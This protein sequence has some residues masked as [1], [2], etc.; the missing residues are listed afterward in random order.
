[1]IL[2]HLIGMKGK[3]I[4]ITLFTCTSNYRENHQYMQ[5]TDKY[6][7]RLEAWLNKVWCKNYGRLSFVEFYDM[8]YDV[9]CL[10]LPIAGGK[11]YVEKS[12]LYS[13]GCEDNM[14]TPKNL[15]GGE[16]HIEIR[17]LG[18]CAVYRI[19]KEEKCENCGTTE[20]IKEYYRP[21]SLLQTSI[22]SHGLATGFS[23][24]K[25]NSDIKESI[26]GVI[27][28]CLHGGEICCSWKTQQIG[29][30][31]LFIRGE[32]TL[33]SNRDMW[34]STNKNGERIFDAD[35]DRYLDNIITR[36]EELDLTVWDHTEFFIIPKDCCGVW[37]EDWFYQ[38]NKDFVK[39]L[40]EEFH[41]FNPN[42][43]LFNTKRRHNGK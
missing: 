35:D 6:I 16:W 9:R 7:K 40:M 33:A 41:R 10:H 1:M 18:L 38:S 12:I 24:H 26:V 34:S 8:S 22:Y 13:C 36:K 28:A 32:V 17:G 15:R 11:V 31:G 3:F 29:G 2:L 19:V 25:S 23:G 14:L 37:V 39:S 4:M 27:D 30:I 21:D 42:L 20:K 5:Y 43:K